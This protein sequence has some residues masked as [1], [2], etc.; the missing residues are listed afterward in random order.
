MV[1]VRRLLVDKNADERED[2][3]KEP[4]SLVIDVVAYKR[5]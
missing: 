1:P 2:V 3:Q 5:T 4:K